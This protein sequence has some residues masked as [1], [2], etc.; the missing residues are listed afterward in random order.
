MADHIV[1]TA[2]V[3]LS[4]YISH[5]NRKVRPEKSNTLRKFLIGIYC[6]LVVL[7]SV[8]SIVLQIKFF[9]DYFYYILTTLV[10]AMCAIDITDIAFGTFSK[11]GTERK[12]PKKRP[13]WVWVACF[14]V[15]WA[16]TF[17]ITLGIFLLAS[18][19]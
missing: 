14:V 17:G 8:L 6:T 4:L 16:I 9:N 15:V 12:P 10:L 13:V 2:A 11:P 19:Y 5:I 7:V 18:N 1:F 3:L